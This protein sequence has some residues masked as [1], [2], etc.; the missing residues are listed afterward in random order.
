MLET[1]NAEPVDAP[2]LAF[3]TEFQGLGFGLPGGSLAALL[4]A[5]VF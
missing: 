2:P 3:S 1:G 5:A 4:C